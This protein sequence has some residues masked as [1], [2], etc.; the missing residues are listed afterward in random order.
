MKRW[1]LTGIIVLLFLFSIQYGFAQSNEILDTLL[2]QEQA[3]LGH[4]A[5][6][7]FLAAEIADEEWSP[8]RATDELRALDWG[9]E[10]AD[11]D[12]TVDLGALSFI[13]MKSF[14]MGGGIMYSLFPGERYAA[15]ELAYLGFVPGYASPYRTLSGREV[16]LIL[17]RTLDH[18]GQREVEL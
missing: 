16:T 8:D 10:E 2:D 18:L 5:Y 11:A 7:V 3:T 13:I 14:D 15:R 12:D 4:T 1:L 6:L 9:F 17:G